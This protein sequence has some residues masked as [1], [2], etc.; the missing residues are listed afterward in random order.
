MSDKTEKKDRDLT[1]KDEGMYVPIS[2]RILVRGKTLNPSIKSCRGLGAKAARKSPYK[3]IKNQSIK[4]R[5]KK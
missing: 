3:A 1:T 4:K 5:N 2:S